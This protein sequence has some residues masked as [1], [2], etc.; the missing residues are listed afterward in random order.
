[1][2]TNRVLGDVLLF[3]PGILFWEQYNG[4][5][6]F[7]HSRVRGVNGVSDVTPDVR[8]VVA[9]EINNR[10]WDALNFLGGAYSCPGE[11]W[12]CVF[13]VFNVG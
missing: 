4:L 2:G 3:R 1:V 9:V 8:S 5:V 13:V 6:V 11:V 7:D 10:F 12:V